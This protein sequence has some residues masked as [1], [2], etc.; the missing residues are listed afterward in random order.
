MGAS[1]NSTNTTVATKA[2]VSAFIAAVEND[3]RRADAKTLVALFRRITGE[4]PKMWGPSIIGFGS[5]HYKYESGREG[6]MPLA[7]FS[8]RKANLVFYLAHCPD[9]DALLARLGKHKTGVGCLYVNTLADVDSA[10]LETLVEKA[11]AHGRAMDG[12]KGC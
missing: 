2:S 3:R 6:D 7:G 5:R 12:G 1:K 11:V 8:P 4:A 9:W 10:V